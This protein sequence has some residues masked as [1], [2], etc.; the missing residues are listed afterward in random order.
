MKVALVVPPWFEV[1][2]RGHGGV[3]TVVATLA[4]AL[5][6]RGHDVLVY[7]AQGGG[8]EAEVRA[9]FDEAQQRYLG[10]RD[11]L[12]VEIAHVVTAYREIA[13]TRPD[14][15]HD[16]TGVMGAAAASLSIHD[17]PALCTIHKPLSEP[18]LR[19]W[20]LLAES[21]NIFISVLSE[22]QRARLLGEVPVSAVVENGVDLRKFKITR[23]KEDYLINIG[24]ICAEKAP[25]VAIEVAKRAGLQLKI[26]GR[27]GTTVEERAYYSEKFEP[28]LGA[29]VEYLGEVGEVGKVELLARARALLFP[30]DWDEPFGLVAIEALASG[31]PVIGTPRGAL[32]EII[33]EGV[34][35]FLREDV[36]GMLDA[37][38]RLDTIDSDQCR[39]RVEERFSA[40]QMAAGYEEAY[41]LT[42]QGVR[43][44]ENCSGAQ[45]T[46]DGRAM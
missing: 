35:G 3:E 25:H 15:V 34:H 44:E 12:Q 20:S 6:Q 28:R 38:R 4:E 8:V 17:I 14:V 18:A 45:V 13:R 10:T 30:V 29:G 7:A 22:F 2:P 46:R 40:E 36:A 5:V 24:R 43:R 39:A 31:T 16:H 26:A 42:A 9:S 11:R 23:H 1:P 19:T 32:P 41:E 33:V 37:V 27:V 21:P